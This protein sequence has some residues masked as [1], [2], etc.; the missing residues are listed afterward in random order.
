MKLKER[1]RRLQSKQS[2]E[3]KE[4][5]QIRGKQRKRHHRQDWDGEEHSLGKQK[6]KTG[7]RLLR[8]EGYLKVH[9]DRGPNR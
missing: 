5:K 7:M 6:A 1:M 3:E 9:F 8:E 2:P 4:Y